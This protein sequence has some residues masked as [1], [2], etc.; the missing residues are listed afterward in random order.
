[1]VEGDSQDRTAKNVNPRLAWVPFEKVEMKRTIRQILGEKCIVTKDDFQSLPGVQVTK[2]L[3]DDGPF[4]KGRNSPGRT[5][6][7]RFG[8][9]CARRAYKVHPYFTDNLRYVC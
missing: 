9:W 8:S 4:G 2:K 5:K 1:L 6:E 7:R 3:A